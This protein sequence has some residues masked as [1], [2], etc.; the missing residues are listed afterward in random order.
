MSSIVSSRTVIR[1]AA[2]TAFVLFTVPS[3]F[4]A[5]QSGKSPAEISGV[6]IEVVSTTPLAGVDLAKEQIAAPV[7]TMNASEIE[8]AGA[9]D[10]SDLLNR[11]L[12]DVSV[13]EIQGNPYQADVNFRGYTASPLLGT[14]QGLSI[15]M[16]GVRLNQ[17]FG[18]IV[19]WDLIPRLAISSMTLMP[20]SNPLFGLNTL[21]GALSMQT[22]DGNT[23]PG[24]TVS[25]AYG[26]H[27]RRSL[28]LEYGGSSAKGWNWYVAGNRFGENGWRPDSH[29][30][31]RQVFGRLGWQHTQTDVHLVVSYANNSLNGN[32][33]QDNRLLQKE[34]SSIYTRPDN[35]HNRAALV[36]LAGK[37]NLS[38]KVLVSG[39][40]Y[41]RDIR[42]S[43]FNG[44]LNDDSLDQALYQPNAAERNALAA[45]GYTGFPLS[46]EN[47]SNTPFP[48]WRCIANVLRND[49][50]GEKCNGLINHSRTTQHNFGLA[51][52]MTYFGTL[53][54][55]KNQFTAGAAF[56]RSGV[57]FAQTTQLGFINPDRSIA[58]LSSFADGVTGGTVDGEPLDT[59]VD[60]HG[61]VGTASI[62]ATDTLSIGSKW[63][64]TGSSRFNRTV[65]HNRDQIHPGGGTGSLD[66]T[67]IFQRL[68]PA[69][70]MTYSP[71][72]GL[73]LYFGYS[74]GS[75]AATS[76][77]LGC[78]DPDE[79]CK[80]PNAM[81]GDPPLKQ[82]V[83]RTWETG[84]RRGSAESFSWNAG[85]F[86]AENHN[87]ILFVTSSAS[88][89][90]YFKNF[91]KTRRQGIEI[92]IS[93]RFLKKL[94]VGGG[95]TFLE[96][97]YR[98]AEDLNGSGNS[99][100]DDGPGLP[101]PIHVAPGDRLPMI[102]RH[103]L[104]S[105]VDYQAFNRL[106]VGLN[107]V[108][109]SSSIA[110]GNENGG[111]EPDGVVY[112]GPGR[113]AGYG[114]VNAESRFGIRKDLDLVMQLNN[115]LNK[116]YA[117]AAQLGS[118]GFTTD[119]NFVA[120]PLPSV[121]GEFPVP[122]ATFLA[123]GAPRQFLVSLRVKI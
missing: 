44:D 36:N 98:T 84:I 9:L 18:E 46:G 79:P 66:G 100:N 59:R 110:R 115:L 1:R 10:L 97:T 113:S 71:A 78:A 83:T 73:N 38:G 25:A 67:H 23:H 35:T 61:T 119:G 30:D 65:V 74:E 111:H 5:Q 45:A 86:F 54:G 43:T 17:P 16:D 41:Y 33:L 12:T 47:A 89:F 70:G 87:D 2:L 42:T 105:F 15:Y 91:G 109:V 120:R 3:A 39:N 8:R 11:H 121:N 118:T 13:N 14:P 49:E 107:L 26:S 114:V 53:A 4:S 34:Y 108:A 48:F 76:I 40:I 62:F 29:S 99:S 60:L 68:N 123:P 6:N 7:Q 112:F 56:D 57:A 69:A 106:S 90:G 20:G 96:A 31:V 52:Q 85:L 64:I 102:P 58:G 63:N 80:L 122:G 28:E 95:Y 75:R 116:R 51:G 103:N 88:G 37:H 94:T 77:E 104:K 117:T 93:D 82:V 22:K 24:G 92:S 81:T 50:P 32:G 72:A 27:L 55:E 101:G 19:S 21:G